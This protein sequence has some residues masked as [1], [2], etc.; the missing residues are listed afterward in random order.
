MKPEF[1]AAKEKMVVVLA[2]IS[3]AI[4]SPV[5]VRDFSRL[6]RPDDCEH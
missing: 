5:S 1:L 3:V 4:S 6:R 2:T